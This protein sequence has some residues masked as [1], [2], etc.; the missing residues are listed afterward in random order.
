MLNPTLPRAT[1]AGS[2]RRGTSSGTMA[3]HAGPLA[4]APRPSRKVKPS[5]DQGVIQPA[6]VSTPRTA[7]VAAIQPCVT[8]SRRRRS[9]TSA[10]APAG[11]ASRKD[12]RLVAAWTS[13][14]STVEV[15]SEVIIQEAPTF[16]SQVPTLDA[17]VAIHS[18]RKSGLRSGDQGLAAAG[19]AGEAVEED[20]EDEEDEV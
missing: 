5:S 12:G 18:Q 20:D 8:S 7:A 1:A 16:C 3:C 2:S 11:S 15:V 4:A 19:A 17:T 10:S 9:T 6:S 14:T 13:A